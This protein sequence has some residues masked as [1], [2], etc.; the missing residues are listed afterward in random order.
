MVASLGQVQGLILHA[1]TGSAPSQVYY[2]HNDRLGTPQVITDET[3]QVVWKADYDPFGE[4]NVVVQLIENNFR[5]PGQYY[6]QETGL[7]QNWFRDYAPGL[8]RYVEADPLFSGP[9]PGLKAARSS[10]WPLR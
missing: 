1:A 8:G 4:A 3:G 9:A 5:F 2:F 6:D 10:P 7:H